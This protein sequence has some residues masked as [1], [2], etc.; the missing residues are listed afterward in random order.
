M[1]VLQVVP[2]LRFS[3]LPQ[4]VRLSA[5][6][7]STGKTIQTAHLS[8]QTFQSCCCCH[9][10]PHWFW[11][12]MVRLLLRWLQAS[13]YRWREKPEWPASTYTSCV[14][15]AEVTVK[16]SMWEQVRQTMHF[17]AI[18]ELISRSNINVNEKTVVVVPR[19]PQTRGFP[20]A[21]Q[22]QQHCFLLSCWLWLVFLKSFLSS[23]TRV[24]RGQCVE[25]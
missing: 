9:Q 18:K 23:K 4:T 12:C 20:R 3:N 7:C 13:L 15:T 11:T 2:W 1:Q 8:S 17:G 5:G 19:C 6:G 14:I 25:Y 16:K 10:Q 22:C 24:T 21:Q